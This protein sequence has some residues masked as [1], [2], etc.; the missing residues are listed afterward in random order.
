[1]KT[2]TIAATQMAC[3]ANPDENVAKAEKLVRSAAAQG[4]QV[5]LLQELFQNQYFCQV[6]DPAFYA[7]AK[8]F[9][10]NEVLAHFQ[11]LAKEL[12]VVL[13]VSF[14]EKATNA[15]FNSLA[16]MDAT[17][18]CL[19]IYRKSH[20][21]HGAGYQEKYYFNP[22]DTG[23]QV[24][25]TAV[26]RIGCGICWDQ[27]FPECARSMVLQG[28]DILLYPTAIGSELSGKAPSSNRKW[29]R[30]MQGHA[31]ANSVIVAAS[32]RI[33][34]EQIAG[35]S[36]HLDFYGSSFIANDYGELVAEAGTDD[37]AVILAT[38]DMD[39][40]RFERAAWGFF[41][42]RRPELYDDLM[43]LDAS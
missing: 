5:V 38:I 26:G 7:L 40:M 23:F 41:R 21:P 37:E 14:F 6:E 30:A 27:W 18:E 1:M 16:I 35:S 39:A 31:A 9:E 20:I 22:G 12:S 11:A 10:G 4:A 17:G 3:S 25:D 32:N 2:V 42:D 24:W 28:A 13:P 15:H 8:P 43:M 34:R 33:G 36:T 19:G 29:Q